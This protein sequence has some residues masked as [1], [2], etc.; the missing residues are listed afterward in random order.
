MHSWEVFKG[1]FEFAVLDDEFRTV[2]VDDYRLFITGLKDNI[3]LST[4]N[5]EFFDFFC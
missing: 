3:N 4:Q 5:F 1:Y 2:A